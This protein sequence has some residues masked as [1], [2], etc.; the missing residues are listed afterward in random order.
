MLLVCVCT[1][2]VGTYYEGR[3]NSGRGG[4]TEP[5]RRFHLLTE[6]R[7]VMTWLAVI[8]SPFLTSCTLCKEYSSHKYPQA[9]F[10]EVSMGTFFRKAMVTEAWENVNPL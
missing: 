5:C 2:W 10:V 3:G 9:L 8:L 4:V 1:G 6:R 7:M